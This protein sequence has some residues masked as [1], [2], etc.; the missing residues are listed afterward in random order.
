MSRKNADVQPFEP[1]GE[2]SLER[3]ADRVNCSLFALGSHSKKRP[4]NLVLGRLYNFQLLDAVELG[5]ERFAAIKSFGGAATAQAGNKPMMLF[6]GERFEP[7]GAHAGV[8]SMLLDFFRGQEVEAV[9]LAGLD[10]VI[11]VLSTSDRALLLRQYAVKL[12]KS[13]T[14]VPRA[15]L[16][17]MGPS[18]DLV[19]RRTRAAPLDLEKEA[20][21]QPKAVKA[22]KVWGV[23]VFVCV[24][25]VACVVCS[26]AFFCD[27]RETRET[28]KKGDEESQLE[29]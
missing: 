16:T 7:G 23:F 29:F 25:V 19:L 14:R 4:H 28:Q 24:C 3:L 20:L 11:C 1:G 10:R 5:V 15:A 17:L 26:V 6:L 12:T 9:N 2:V 18:L 27:R 13:G 8:K 21:K 22:K